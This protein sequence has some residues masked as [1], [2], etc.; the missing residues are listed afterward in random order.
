MSM[1]GAQTSAFQAAAG[2]PP[3]A[4]EGL[5]IGAAMTFLLLWSA[6]AMYSTWRGWATN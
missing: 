2:F 5:F 3:S 6:W 4:G 1:S